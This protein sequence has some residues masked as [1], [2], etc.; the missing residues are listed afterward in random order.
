MALVTPDPKRRGDASKEHDG[1]TLGKLALSDSG[2]DGTIIDLVA[3]RQQVEELAQC[4][5]VPHSG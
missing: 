3:A 5:P 4:R 2:Q 1:T